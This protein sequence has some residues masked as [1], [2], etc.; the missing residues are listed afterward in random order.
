MGGDGSVVQRLVGRMVDDYL[1][2]YEA[3]IDST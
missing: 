1:A 3:V 2:A